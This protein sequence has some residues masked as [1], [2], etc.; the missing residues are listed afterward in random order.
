M[1]TKGQET[2]MNREFPSHDPTTAP[3]AA[4]AG[5][6]AASKRFG[7]LPSPLAKLATA[8][9]VMAFVQRALGAF[10]ETSLTSLEREVVAM[11]M[12]RRN[13]CHYC[14]ALHQKMLAALP[15][16]EAVALREGR[17][18]EAPRLVALERFI[19]ALLATHGDVDDAAW[20]EFRAAGF[21]HEQA[22]EVTL[23]VGAYTLSTYLN[24]LTQA[25]VDEAVA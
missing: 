2:P 21:T 23:G 19:S 25:P 5:L 24:R 10:E 22:L 17:P 6:A 20:Q 14:I 15:E 18:L 7:S 13:G 9:L 16:P 4:R 8:P 12:A 11:T 3:E 1:T